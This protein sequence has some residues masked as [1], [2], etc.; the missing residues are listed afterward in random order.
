[1]FIHPLL[2]LIG[3]AAASLPVVIHFMTKP[4]PIRMPLSTIRL[5]SDALHQRRSK[6]RLRDIIVLL[7]RSLA[8]AM[9]AVAIAR[10]LLTGD[11]QPE[12][13]ESADRVKVVLLDASQSMA[14][15]DGVS[16]RFDKARAEAVNELSYKS[17]LAA[18]L[19]VA[20]HSS[21]AIFDAP[22]ANLALLRDRLASATV[23]A[24]GIDVNKA[25][26]EA[27]RQLSQSAPGS[28]R[29]L[30]IL[31]DFQRSSWSRANFALLPEDTEIRVLSMAQGDTPGNLAIEDVRLTSTPMVGKPV[32]VLV[33]VANHSDDARRVKCQVSLSNINRVGDALIEPHAKATVTI[34]VD[35]SEPGWQYGEARLLETGDAIIADD[36]FPIAV[37]VKP[38]L[39]IAIVTDS[40]SR[41]GTAAHFAFQAL[42]R[43]S[44][45]D[46]A[47]QDSRVVTL[48][49]G[50]LDTPPAQIASVWIL[51]DVESWDDATVTRVASWLRRG[52]AI[53]YI[54]RSPVDANNL[55]KLETKLAAEMQPP[56]QLIASLGSADRRDLTIGEIDRMNPPL[57]V[58]GDALDEVV[59]DWRFVGGLPTRTLD[60][61]GI[62]DITATLSDRSV[63][64]YF[65]DVGAGKLAVLNADIAKSNLAYSASFVPFLVESIN[66]LTDLGGSITATASGQPVLRELPVSPEYLGRVRVER[67][68]DDAEESERIGSIQNQEGVM[69]WSWPAAELPGVYRVMDSND[70]TLWAEAI[71]TERAEQ[72]LAALSKDVLQSR[73]SGGRKFEF[74]SSSS[75]K[76]QMDTSWVWATIAMLGC[77]LG[78]LVALTWF[79][80]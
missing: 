22:S 13:E 2:L 53:F 66:R 30:V 16:T 52:K 75:S 50:M 36:R 77:V 69:V 59:S 74:Q 65:T 44:D 54:V 61:A 25:I 1:M 3:L 29:E 11:T 14:A 15:I 72:N 26:E 51:C 71:C 38:E 43:P 64:M 9:L 39:R 58:F 32:T 24:S 42:S 47:Q 28:I 8:I 57:S 34:A 76:N 68:G 48:P 56:V 78:E 5:V 27:A 18:N 37:G 62:D 46:V 63:L 40:E 41:P 60:S 80:S 35:W 19:L 23:S 33:D 6:D 73:L 45:L 21:G 31:S 7:L 10:P 49:P 20:S 67:E 70:K 79:R 12:K 17:G 55:Q 4:K